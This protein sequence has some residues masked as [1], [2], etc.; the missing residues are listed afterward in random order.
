MIGLLMIDCIFSDEDYV[1]V[2]TEEQECS[3]QAV[4]PQSD[5]S[6]HALLED[7]RSPRSPENE[8]LVGDQE[9]QQSQRTEENQPLDGHHDV[10]Q[11][12]RSQENQEVNGRQEVLQSREITLQRDV[13][14]TSSLSESARKAKRVLFQL[15]T[16]S[17]DASSAKPHRGSKR[18]S[19]QSEHVTSSP[20]KKLLKEKNQRRKHFSKTKKTTVTRKAVGKKTRIMLLTV[21]KMKYGLAW[22][23]A[24]HIPTVGPEKN[25][26]SATYASIGP[27]KI[28]PLVNFIM[29]VKIAVRMMMT[30]RIDSLFYF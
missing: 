5:M 8:Q 15:C 26:F 13:P 1:E 22:Y 23:A 28:A 25:G 19:E 11:S 27:T 21:L 29:S 6:S 10:Q 12:Q 7:Q 17:Q 14:S 9:A 3:Q 30:A 2:A 20:H 4:S 16:P 18:V 24:N